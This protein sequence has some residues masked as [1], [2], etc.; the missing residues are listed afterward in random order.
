MQGGHWRHTFPAGV[1][2]SWEE[3]GKEKVV[4]TGSGD[5]CGGS[6]FSRAAGWDSPALIPWLPLPVSPNPSSGICCQ[7][8]PPLTHLCPRVSPWEAPARGASASQKN[9]DHLPY[10]SGGYWILR[11][12]SPSGGTLNGQSQGGCGYP[13]RQQSQRSDHS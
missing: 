13:N 4:G 10:M 12:Q 3:W 5:G 8:G 9:S 6:P 1:G 7:P 2:R 11:C